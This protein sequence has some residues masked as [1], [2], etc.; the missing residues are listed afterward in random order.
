M[1]K[2]T[3]NKHYVNNKEFLLAMTD[4]REKRLAAEEKR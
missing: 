2:K 3:T 4:Y 1:S